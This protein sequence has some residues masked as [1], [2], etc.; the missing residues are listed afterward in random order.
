MSIDETKLSPLSICEDSS[1]LKA[2]MLDARV[3]RDMSP[4]WRIATATNAAANSVAS[5]KQQ[6]SGGLQQRQVTV[7]RPPPVE[8]LPSP[9]ISARTRSSARTS[10][11]PS[12]PN[13]ENAMHAANEAAIQTLSNAWRKADQQAPPPRQPRLRGVRRVLWPE[14]PGEAPQQTQRAHYEPGTTRL[15]LD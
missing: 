10:S 2:A 5:L 14:Q 4:P 7:P 12:D 9:R 13:D 15:A 6:R 8:V 1:V 11:D 3:D